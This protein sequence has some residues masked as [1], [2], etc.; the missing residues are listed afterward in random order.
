MTNLA[1]LFDMDGCLV[2]TEPVIN[3]AAI[4]ALKEW[5]V[6]A[7]PEDF[8]PF[9]GRGE[10]TYISGV[11]EKYGVD[12]DSKMKDRVYEIY[13]EI[14]EEMLT[15]HK[16]ALECLAELN[17]SNIPMVLASAA[18]H[19]K[20][21]ANLRVA[22]IDRS[23]FQAILGAEDVKEKKPAPDIYL[24]AAKAVSMPPGQCIV[25]ED[26]PNGI[27]AAHNANMRCIALTT[28]F[29]RKEIKQ[30]YPEFI[31]ENLFQ[32]RDVVIKLYGKE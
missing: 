11:A 21:D 4:L 24:T 13:L 26:A 5:G 23:I 30:Q 17:R 31:C 32:V 1:V 8:I 27:Q 29:D 20:I 19:L 22:G 14:V 6:K 10:T 28:T 12:Y 9:I 2:D 7:K 15:P 16:G 18:D 3:K 25:V